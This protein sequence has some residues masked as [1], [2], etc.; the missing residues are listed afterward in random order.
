MIFYTNYDS[1]AVSWPILIFIQKTGGQGAFC[2]VHV[3]TS[4][5]LNNSGGKYYFN[6][7]SIPLNSVASD[8]STALKLWNLSEK[9]VGL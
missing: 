4:P 5:D 6:C 9:Y 7:K 8:E 1:D 3:A 2:S